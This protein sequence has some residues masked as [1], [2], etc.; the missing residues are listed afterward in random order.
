MRFCAWHDAIITLSIKRCSRQKIP[1][2]TNNYYSAFPTNGTVTIKACQQLTSFSTWQVW[3]QQ[4]HS[5][6]SPFLVS[7]IQTLTI[8]LECLRW[9]ISHRDN[10]WI[11]CCELFKSTS[12]FEKL[13]S[14]KDAIL[15]IS[16]WKFAQPTTRLLTSRKFSYRVPVGCSNENKAGVYNWTRNF[17]VMH[18]Q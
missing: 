9:W 12:F 3:Q 5:K 15:K 18:L 7:F 17:L 4:S 8:T 10:V 1:P 14:E 16:T 2:L 13:S 6:A 11:L